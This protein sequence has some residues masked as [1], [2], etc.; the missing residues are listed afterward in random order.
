MP[1]S[2]QA[3][4]NRYP[5]TI[6]AASQRQNSL[7]KDDR[8]STSGLLTVAVLASEFVSVVSGRTVPRAE[9]TE[10]YDR[11]ERGRGEEACHL[12]D[13]LKA[14]ENLVWSRRAPR[15]LPQS[16]LLNHHRAQSKLRCKIFCPPSKYAQW[17]PSA[18]AVAVENVEALRGI[19]FYKLV[20]PAAFGG[21]EYDFAVLVDLIVEI[22]RGCAST[23]WVCGL[24]AAHQWML[25]L[26]PA[27][28]QHE[29]WGSNPHATLCGS[30]APACLAVSE[31]N[32]Y[33]LHGRWSFAS[34]CDNAQW[35]ICSA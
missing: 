27:R 6:C 33:R 23:S 17:R 4:R 14:R 3:K 13:T 32:G 21:Y 26:F 1:S 28:A 34:G 29:I 15:V 16:K 24:L 25:G 22:G 8:L 35:A 30:Y 11:S 31:R 18:R 12:A 2:S 9:T 20:Q 19:G 10:I 5:G 7:A